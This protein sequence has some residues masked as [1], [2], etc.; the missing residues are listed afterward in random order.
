MPR[1]GGE[2]TKAV[3]LAKDSAS[4]DSAAG[5]KQRPVCELTSI[6]ISREEGNL[7]RRAGQL[8]HGI[9]RERNSLSLRYRFRRR[10]RSG[11]AQTGRLIYSY[12]PAARLSASV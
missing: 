11:C 6:W 7:V 10:P 2:R 1:G 12:P 3:C 9:S 5:T 4:R 8:Y